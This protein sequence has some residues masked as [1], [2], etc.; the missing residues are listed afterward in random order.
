VKLRNKPGY[1]GGMLRKDR[2]DV[3]I[4][5]K[6]RASERGCGTELAVS[7]TLLPRKLKKRIG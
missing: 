7:D 1:L 4:L 3:W 6:S 5:F 2:T